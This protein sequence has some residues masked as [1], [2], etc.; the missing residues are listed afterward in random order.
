MK[1]LSEKIVERLQDLQA[2]SLE[3]RDESERHRGHSG[4]GGGGHYSMTIVSERFSG[5]SLTARHRLVYG[6]LSDLMKSEI[7]ALAIQAYTP[8]EYHLK[9]TSPT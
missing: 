2:S 3:I 9:Q 1:G 5:Q 6:M 4:S 8:S 7:H